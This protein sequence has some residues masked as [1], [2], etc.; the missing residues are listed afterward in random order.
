MPTT[1]A[2]NSEQTLIGPGWLYLN[3]P[4]PATGVAMTLTVDPVTEVP[5]PTAGL[6]VGYTTNGNKFTS[7][8]DL[9]TIEA[10][11]SQ[12]AAFH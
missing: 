6:L 10:D 2:R 4:I 8:F 9:V 1:G 3:V 5:A 7:G 12:S 11:E